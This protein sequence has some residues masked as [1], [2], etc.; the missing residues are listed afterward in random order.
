MI[1]V[2]TDSA[3]SRD[4]DK[5][6][7]RLPSGMRDEIAAAATK[8]G[9]SMNAEIVHRIESSISLE[10]RVAAL[11]EQTQRLWR[12]LVI[13]HDHLFQADPAFAARVIDAE[14]VAQEIWEKRRAQ[15]AEIAEVAKSRP[16]LVIEDEPAPRKP[17]KG[18]AGGSA[19]KSK[20]RG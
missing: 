17:A 4:L 2:M 3:P 15:T 20:R 18:S 11:D 7:L 1:R 10:A 19:G 12:Q 8:S 14:K 16:V 13:A 5:F 6:V 9:R